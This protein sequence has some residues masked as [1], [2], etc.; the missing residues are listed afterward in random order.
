MNESK[1][2]TRRRDE[3]EVPG[4]GANVDDVQRL[5][6]VHQEGASSRTSRACRTVAPISLVRH[7]SSDAPK[8]TSTSSRPATAPVA[9]ALAGWVV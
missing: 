4:N 9:V 1:I 7:S 2:K 5:G 3:G 8:W 6:A